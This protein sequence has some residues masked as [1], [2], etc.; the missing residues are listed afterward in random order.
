MIVTKTPLRLSFFGGSTDIS[1]FYSNSY[2]A[3]LTTS[4]AKYIHVCIAPS[5]H[6]NIKL[7]YTKVESVPTPEQLEHSLMRA[8]LVKLGVRKGIE[9][10]TMADIPSSGTGLGSSSALAIGTLNGLYSYKGVEKS[11]G[12]LAEEACDIEINVLKKPIGKQDQYATALGGLRYIRFNND[13]TVESERVKISGQTEA[14]LKQ[15]LM[16]F[17][18]ANDRDGDGLLKAQNSNISSNMGALEKMR[19]QAARGRDL[20]RSGH[21]QEFGAL[22]DEAWTLKM[23]LSKSVTNPTINRYYGLAMESGAI[24]GKLSGAGGSGFITVYCEPGKQQNVREALKG[25]REVRL[26]FD[27]DGTKVVYSD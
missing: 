6:E 16:S 14:E 2:G 8:I 17:Y 18:V 25:L 13:G 12:E 9:I 15:N 21:L 10:F 19:D 3:V 1:N 26:G 20:L 22:L 24:G 7:G 4:V 5:F 11:S 23:S 27:D